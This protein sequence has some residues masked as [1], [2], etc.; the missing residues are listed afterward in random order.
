M[1]L[2]LWEQLYPILGAIV[3]R[4]GENEMLNVYSMG[5]IDTGRQVKSAR[6]AAGLSQRE[7]AEIIGVAR[8]TVA[9]YEGGQLSVSLEAIQAISEATSHPVEF[10]LASKELEPIQKLRKAS[11]DLRAIEIEFELLTMLARH[12]NGREPIDDVTSFLK[13]VVPEDSAIKRERLIAILKEKGS[14]GS[15]E[16]YAAICAVFNLESEET[17]SSSESES[18]G[19]ADGS[20]LSPKPNWNAQRAKRKGPGEISSSHGDPT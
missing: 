15:G 12:L 1:L 17:E 20:K 10:F 4:W 2:P 5:A 7:L 6:N 11:S 18:R 3:N 19:P 13:F 8:N 16:A 9:K 14:G